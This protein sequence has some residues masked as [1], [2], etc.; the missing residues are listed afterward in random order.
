MVKSVFLPCVCSMALALRRDHPQM[1]P[2][3]GDSCRFTGEE[4]RFCVCLLSGNSP[5]IFICS[6]SQ[7]CFDYEYSTTLQL[8][9]FWPGPAV[10]VGKELV[11]RTLFQDSALRQERPV[12]PGGGSV[13]GNG[14][15]LFCTSFIFTLHLKWSEIFR[16]DGNL[17]SG[18]S[19][20]RQFLEGQRFFNQEFGIHCKEVIIRNDL[21]SIYTCYNCYKIIM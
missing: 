9:L 21:H 7:I 16:Q 15:R 5:L 2:K 10:S 1:W 20:V 19:M 13:G 18:E 4:P 14:K 6:K 17:P 12:C 3:L 11:P 8:C